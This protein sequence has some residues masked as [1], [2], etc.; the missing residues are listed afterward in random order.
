[1]K[2]KTKTILLA[3]FLAT[4]V[5]G[6]AV[7]A[8]AAPRKKPKPH[9]KLRLNPVINNPQAELVFNDAQTSQPVFVVQYYKKKGL[10]RVRGKTI[11]NVDFQVITLGNKKKWTMRARKPSLGEKPLFQITSSKPILRIIGSTIYTR[12][13]YMSFKDAEQAGFRVTITKTSSTTADVTLTKTSY[14]TQLVIDPVVGLNVETIYLTFDVC[15]PTWVCTGYGACN[16]SDQAPCN[17]VQDTHCGYP[18]TQYT[19]DYT[20]FAPISCNYCTPTWQET[21]TD[22]TLNKQNITY[23]YTNNCCALTGL[24]SDCT[25]PS[26]QTDVA[27]SLFSYGTEGDLS[28]AIPDTIVKILAGFAAVASLF[29]I[30][31]I[32]VRLNKMAKKK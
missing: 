24:P 1:M 25:L 13:H 11:D 21:K 5:I 12:T 14:G 6:M 22:C 29:G 20:E 19:G 10:T 28:A 3:V 32:G 9:K 4:L 30:V 31:F 16:T 2:Q 17:A 18:S 23:E 27:C 15:H 7:T 26:N 8:E